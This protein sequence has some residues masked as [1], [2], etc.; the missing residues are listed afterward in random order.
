[1]INLAKP[2]LT[3][4]DK[5][6][7]IKVM[8]SNWHSLGPKKKEF[9]QNFAKFCGTK[10]SLA[11]NSGTSALHLC[12]LASGIKEGD[13]II[14][15]PFS[16]IAS[17]NCALMCGAR[18]VFVD[19]DPKTFNLDP[20]KI[21]QAITSRTKA[22]LPVHIFG[23]SCDMDPIIQIAKK[24]NL[25]IIEDA[26][27][28]IGAEYNGKKV[29]TFGKA[30]TFAFYPNKQLNTGEGGMIVTDDKE[31]Y[32]LCDSLHNQGRSDS[33]QW[34]TH[35]YLGYNYRIS[36]FNCALGNSQL[37]RI[38]QIINKRRDVA[39]KYNLAL[40]NIR[41]IN[42]PSV[43]DY[44]THTW[45]VYVIQLDKKFNRNEIITELNKLGVQTKPYL[46]AIHLQE[47]YINKFN[48]KDGDFP[49]CEDIS[50]RSLAL[51]FYESLSDEEINTV[52]TKLNEVLNNA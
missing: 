7:V 14:T 15:S 51:P 5:Q 25:M 16:F 44:T 19:V 22:I 4:E 31:F 24:H 50:N 46:P 20:K 18:P 38:Q 37:K 43:A 9:E 30:G 13:E 17:A 33:G 29:G 48:Y 2:V 47:L 6:A 40:A 8:N 49:I 52:V 11:V 26:C 21:E 32:E 1:M 23:Q 39:N 12:M 3:D 41:N 36:E 27:E 34:L 10:Y 35:K 45:F 42:L 28:S